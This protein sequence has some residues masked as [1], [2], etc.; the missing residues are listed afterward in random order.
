MKPSQYSRL[1]VTLYTLLAGALGAGI[2]YWLSFPFY[3]ITGPAILITLLS[4]AGLRFEIPDPVRDGAFLLMGIFMGS[5]MN[6]EASAAFMRWPVAFFALAAQLV[7]IVLICGWIMQ[8]F[9][10]YDRRSAVLAAS[11]GHLSYVL[12]L[13]I[14]LDVNVSRV[15]VVQSVR[16][17]A[18]TLGGT[19]RAMDES[20]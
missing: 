2:A 1:I 17:L 13:G 19:S 7:G 18:L 3:I 16:L 12:S 4:L 6:S 8:K 10:N 11:P 14:S 15:A 9:F 5:G 20:R